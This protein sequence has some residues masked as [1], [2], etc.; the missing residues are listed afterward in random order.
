MP[1]AT[2]AGR[3]G[4]AERQ[5]AREF[6]EAG[7]DGHGEQNADRAPCTRCGGNGGDGPIGRRLRHEVPGDGA[8]DARRDGYQQNHRQHE[9]SWVRHWLTSLETINDLA[10]L[11]E[12]V[13]RFQP[14]KI[15]DRSPQRQRPAC[16]RSGRPLVLLER[17]TERFEQG[18]IDRVALRV[19]F[20]VPLHA[21]CKA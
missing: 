3:G 9:T 19:V 16:T 14:R 12:P 10:D 13:P 1:R 7:G 6:C 11:V 18:A 2:G 20:G 8:R 4:S 21:E 17:R 5:I 15:T